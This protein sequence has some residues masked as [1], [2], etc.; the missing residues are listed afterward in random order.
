VGNPLA[1]AKLLLD[2]LDETAGRDAG[3]A[4]R[5]TA[6]QTWRKPLKVTVTHPGGNTRSVEVVT[7]NLSCGGLS[8]LH[9]GF[10]HTGTRCDL[11]LTTTDGAWVDVHATV[12]RC[13]YVAGRV[14]EI[15]LS[16]DEPVDDSRFVSQELSASILLVDDSEDVLRLTKHYLTKAGAEVVTADRG[17]RAL[18][19]VAEKEFDLVLLDVEMPGID[20]PSAAKTLRER[21][22]TIPIIAYTASDDQ[23]TREK[24]LAAGC[25]DVLP[26]PLGKTQ[27]IEAMTRYLAVEEPI[28]S[29]HAGNPEIA[30]FI[31]DFVTSLPA[32]MQEMQRCV[33]AKNA[34]EL[35]PL[36]RQ[37]KTA[38]SDAG[39]CGFDELSTAANRLAKTLTGTVAWASVEAAMS[40]LSSLS[41]R[42]RET[43]E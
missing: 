20:G 11:Q 10:L 33:Q 31:H 1:D 36:A 38:A 22:L 14:H 13:R 2:S 41:H 15:N 12:V 28:T 34:E 42:V 16:F 35:G 6:R 5:R 25:S 19:L 37:L 9:D 7:R 8:F 17:F 26:K 4:D 18:K 32:R 23:A 40:A 43:K 29:K 24:C 21:G 27:L 30:D 3:A 39:G